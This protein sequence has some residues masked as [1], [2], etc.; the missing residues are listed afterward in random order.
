MPPALL[1]VFS[2][3]GAQVQ[4]DEFHDWYD[5]EHIPLRMNLPSFLTGARFFASDSIQP[6]WAALYDVD[7]ASSFKAGSYTR[8]RTL[9]S[10][11][12]AALVERLEV[13]D[14]RMY[15]LVWDSGKLE[16]TVTTSLGSE[17]PTRVFITHGVE[18]TSHGS[19]EQGA[20][21]V[22]D[23]GELQLVESWAEVC[24]R[25]KGDANRGW[26]RT[27]VLKC[28]EHGRTGTGALKEQIVPK[29]L[30]LHELTSSSDVS[31]LSDAVH[32]LSSPGKAGI[33]EWRRWVLYRAFPGI[34]QGNIGK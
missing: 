24:G 27:R 20:G 8:L 34:A 32:S 22:P 14:R 29:Y 15:E 10:Q 33:V 3:P 30:F 12:E 28:I 17:N 19:V 11:R 21:G 26:L 6:S 31:A 9:R 5:N 25:L 1:L 7:D 23:V 2:E 16:E 18:L 13:L 4:L